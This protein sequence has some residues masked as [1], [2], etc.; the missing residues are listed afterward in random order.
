MV[1]KKKVAAGVAAI[2][3][4]MT[5]IFALKSRYTYEYMKI[6]A[7]LDIFPIYITRGHEIIQVNPDWE[8][9][10]KAIKCLRDLS[11]IY[12]DSAIVS[13]I[14]TVI[15]TGYATKDYISKGLNPL[16]NCEKNIIHGLLGKRKLTPEDFKFWKYI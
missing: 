11:H 14:T 16:Y 9:A 15:S 8:I 6:V 5:I 13:G 3:G 1:N 12:R 4:L 2:T 7:N 10:Q